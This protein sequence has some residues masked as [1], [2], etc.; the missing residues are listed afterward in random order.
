MAVINNLGF[1]ESVAFPERPQC[2]QQQGVRAL[3]KKGS[4]HRFQDSSRYS[5]QCVAS[6]QFWYVSPSGSQGSQTP[7]YTTCVAS[8]ENLN[9]HI[10]TQLGDTK[11]TTAALEL[12]ESI[13]YLQHVRC[14]AFQRVPV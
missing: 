3:L 7:F 12:H 14:E 13:Y 2:F 1:S 10:S 4:R 5:Q 9:L 11:A 6:A 8:Y